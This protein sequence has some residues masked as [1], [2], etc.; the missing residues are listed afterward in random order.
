VIEPEEGYMTSE[1]EMISTYKQ[2]LFTALGNKD[3]KLE[4]LQEELTM[5]QPMVTTVLE[6][7]QRARMILKQWMKAARKQLI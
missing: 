5:G 2:F 7:R 6:F 1:D 3:L 4:R